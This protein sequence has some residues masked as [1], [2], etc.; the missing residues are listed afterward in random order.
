[1]NRLTR[2]SVLRGISAVGVAAVGVSALAACVAT[3]TVAPSVTEAET[4]HPTEAVSAPTKAAEQAK[5]VFAAW[6]DPDS[7]WGKF[8]AHWIEEFQSTHEGV[9]VEYQS[10][11]WADYHTKLLTQV[12]G[13]AAPDAFAHSNVYYPKFIAKGGAVPLEDLIANVPDY[14]LEDFIPTSLHLST[15]KGKLYGLPHI[16]SAFTQ[17][18]NKQIFG[19]LGLP[20]PNELDAKGE[21][22][23]ETFLDCAQKATKR[24]AS[25]KA[26]RLGYGGAWLNYRGVSSWAWQNGGDVLKQPNLDEF[27]L[28]LDPGA[29]AVQFMADLINKYKVSPAAGE[30]LVDTVS[31]FNTGRI[32]MFESWAN[33]GWLGMDKHEVG[34]LVYPSKNKA[35]VTVLHTNSLGIFKGTKHLDLAWD[36]ISLMTSKEGDLSQA[37]F[38]IGIVLRE[39]NLDTMTQIFGE[40][41]HVDHPEVVADIIRTGRTY[42]ITETHAEENDIFNPA[43]DEVTAGNKAAKEVL[44]AIKPELDALLA[45]HKS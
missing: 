33:L 44:D 19:E 35:R 1:M 28:N 10:T 41:F 25:G 40:R 8:C 5:L 42:D 13:G 27:V 24:D 37:E 16:S 38:G 7:P 11:P 17:V 21:W 26:E 34:D 43:I 12:A 39:S 9:T 31:D 45:A 30:I 18:W 6:G 22:T 36:L 32:A 23:W 3:P 14:D 4:P 2:R 20:S 15:Y 29:E